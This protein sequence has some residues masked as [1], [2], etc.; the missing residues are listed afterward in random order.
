MNAALLSR[1]K[2][3]VLKSLDEGAIV[4]ILRKALTDDERGLGAPESEAEDDAL[5]RDRAVRQR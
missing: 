4:S 3:F 5:A 1:S 2:V